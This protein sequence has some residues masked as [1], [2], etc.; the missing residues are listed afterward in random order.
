MTTKTHACLTAA[1]QAARR[2]E[3]EKC[4][5]VV[6]GNHL[7]SGSIGPLYTAGWEAS[8]GAGANAIR[9]LGSGDEE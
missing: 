6:A 8:C 4:A 5:E 3:R 9:A 1:Q 7:I 2:D